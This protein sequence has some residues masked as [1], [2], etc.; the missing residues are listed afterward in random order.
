MAKELDP[1]LNSRLLSELRNNKGLVLFTKQQQGRI[2]NLVTR[3]AREGD[4]QG[5]RGRAHRKFVT[6]NVRREYSETGLYGFVGW[7]TVLSLIFQ[8]IKI[9]QNWRQNQ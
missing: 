6:K 3:Y 9:Y 5:L 2:I 4:D 8:A 7:L 1:L